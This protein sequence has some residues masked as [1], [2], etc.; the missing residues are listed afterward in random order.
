MDVTDAVI[1]PAPA[2]VGTTTIVTSA[3]PP[4]AKTS[5]EQLATPNA[6]VHPEPCVAVADTNVAPDGR[7]AVKSTTD[8]ASGPALTTLKVYV[9]GSPIVAGSA[10]TVALTERSATGS[11]AGVTRTA[12][13]EAVA[14]VA[15]GRSAENP[16]V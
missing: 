12:I 15:P 9:R 11:L 3:E 14:V 1:D 5:S 16:N 10:D 6:S 13:G 7:T 2:A 4:F 8:A